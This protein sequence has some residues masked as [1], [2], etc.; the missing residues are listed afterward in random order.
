MHC[1]LTH[2]RGLAVCAIAASGVGVDAEYLDTQRD[3]TAV[4]DSYFSPDERR[5]LE[6]AS[7]D[8]RTELFFTLWTLKEAFAKATR[9]ELESLGACSFNPSPVRFQT[10]APDLGTR[11]WQADS[12]A[13]TGCHRVSYVVEV[14]SGQSIDVV[15]RQVAYC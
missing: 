8:R 12:F 10:T 9:T 11:H 7:P 14:P 4:A 6:S 3:Y 2:T 5:M 15:R 13:P 1:S